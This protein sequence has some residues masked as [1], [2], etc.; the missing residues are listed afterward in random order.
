MKL[1]PPVPAN[2][3]EKS[4][5]AAMESVRAQA[6]WCP[7]IAEIPH[8]ELQTLLSI[9]IRT[10]LTNWSGQSPQT[11]AAPAKRP[12][13]PAQQPSVRTR[14]LQRD[15]YICYLCNKPIAKPDSSID[16]VIPKAKGG[17]NGMDNLRAAHKECNFR[18]A[19]MSL[20]EY[21]RFTQRRP[22]DHPHR[23]G[24]QTG[25]P[26]RLFARCERSAAAGRIAGFAC[27]GTW[28]GA[29]RAGGRE[30][31]MTPRAEGLR[32]IETAQ[33][34]KD[35]YGQLNLHVHTPEG[36]R[37]HAWLSLRPVYCDRGHI[38]LNIDGPLS[39]DGSDS[40]PRFFFSFRE[41]D[42]HTRTFLKWR[43]WKERTHPHVLEARSN[44]QT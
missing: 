8:Y 36:H 3:D 44:D 38:Q 33:W 10:F 32:Q 31:R 43:L 21:R 7:R 12:K 40:F 41:A 37:V 34:T 11:A 6:G 9:G 14:V 17:K 28:A 16:H 13:G 20:D 30:T 15:G 24:S 23:R 2:L 29:R 25:V 19:D 39:L 5:T 22:H 18:K 4:L 26:A 42:E 35:E 27:G 1:P